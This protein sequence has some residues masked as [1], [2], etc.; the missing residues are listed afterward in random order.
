MRNNIIRIA[1]IFGLALSIACSGKSGSEAGT[2]GGVTSK[3]PES[4]D[5]RLVDEGNR[6]R[7]NA[8]PSAV[9]PGGPGRGFSRVGWGQRNTPLV[10]LTADEKQ[11]VDIK[12]ATAGFRDMR[13][14]L[15]AM[16]K[17]LVPPNKKAIVSYAFPARISE[18]HVAIGQWVEAG[19]KLVT[20]Q[21]EAVG[22]AKSEYFKAMADHE[23]ANRNFER[24]KNLYERGV[25]AQKN[26]LAAEAE[27]KV[28]DASLMA[29]EKKL[30]LLGFSEDQVRAMAEVHQVNPVI[31]LFAP[32]SGKIIDN[33]A[34]LGGMIDQSIEILTIMNPM[35]LCIDAEIYERDIARI[36]TGQDVEITVP[37]YPGDLFRGNICYISDILNE[38]TRT[39]TVRTEVKNTDQRLKP[40]M[41]ASM[42]IFFR[43]A[44][45]VLAVPEE[46]VLDDRG[47]SLVFVC[48]RDGFRP[49]IVETGI[50]DDGHREILAGLA[51]GEEVV[52]SGGFQLKSKLYDDILKSAHAH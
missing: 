49:R 25:G 35:V 20:L 10:V 45:R 17:V 46:A 27:Y 31:A 33:K 12:T 52:T 42:V 13:S 50:R 51:E 2:N 8:S 14:R 34:V 41:F 22:A 16:G 26:V 47:E 5:K 19:Q 15:R 32:L 38:E 39:V 30:H 21:S 23:L 3:P 28:A 43:E 1:T 9:Q 6:G 37:A 48:E 24:E 7:A 18:I 4:S 36:R 40:G 29:A 11:A 44:A